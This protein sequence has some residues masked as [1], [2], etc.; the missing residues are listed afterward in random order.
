[1][2]MPWKL[3]EPATK[4]AQSDARPKTPM[5]TRKTASMMSK[6]RLHPLCS[7]GIGFS[8]EGEFAPCGVVAPLDSI[9]QPT[10]IGLASSLYRIVR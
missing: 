8:L 9:P 2:K 6:L 1:M 5:M 3:P 4:D 7:E 10:N